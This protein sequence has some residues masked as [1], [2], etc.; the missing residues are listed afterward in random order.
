[1]GSAVQHDC[2]AFA[3]IDGDLRGDREVFLAALQQDVSMLSETSRCPELRR[4]R[5]MLLWA[6]SRSGSMLQYASKEL[7]ADKELVLAAVSQDPGA[8]AWAYPALR[9]DREVLAAMRQACED[10]KTVEV[11]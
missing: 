7:R 6:V 11:Q 9:G 8:L 1:M 2:R 3:Y 5:E 4:D 10:A